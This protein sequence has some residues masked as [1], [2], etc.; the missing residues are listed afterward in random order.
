MERDTHFRPVERGKS[1]PGHRDVY[2]APPSLRNT[3]KGVPGGFF[4]TLDKCK[5]LKQFKTRCKDDMVNS[6][7]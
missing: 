2:G 6:D 1:F 3:E 4:L 5:K 7:N